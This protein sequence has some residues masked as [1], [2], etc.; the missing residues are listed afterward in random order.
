MESGNDF[1]IQLKKNRLRL[2]EGINRYI[3]KKE[4]TDSYSTLDRNRGRI[5]IRYYNTYDIAAFKYKDWE[6]LNCVVQV[7]RSGIR[8][9]KPY[10]EVSLYISNKMYSAKIFAHGIRG[11]WGVENLIHREKD[12][13]HN[14]DKNRIKDFQMAKNVSVLQTISLNLLRLVK[15]QTLLQGHEK[16]ANRPS[17]CKKLISKS[18]RI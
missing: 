16:Y 5:D 10:E 14:E 6:H 13:V 17:E 3:I 7:V 11:H 15:S 8:N 9:K 18:L 12:V 1:V 2:L 4:L